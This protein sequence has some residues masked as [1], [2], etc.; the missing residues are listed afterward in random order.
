M[1]PPLDPEVIQEMR[2]EQRSIV[3][4]V[5][6]NCSGRSTIEIDTYRIKTLE[7]SFLQNVS[8]QVALIDA[9]RPIAF[10]LKDS[11]TNPEVFVPLSKRVVMLRLFDC[12]GPRVTGKLPSLNLPSLLLFIVHRCRQPINVLKAD[13]ETNCLLRGVEFTGTPLAFF[14]EGSFTNL[15]NLRYLALE[16]SGNRRGCHDT[17]MQ[18]LKTKLHCDCEYRWL[19]I[20]LAKNPTVIS[21]I[22]MTEIID[23]GQQY[24]TSDRIAIYTPIDCANVTYSNCREPSAQMEYS[25][26][27]PC[28]WK[29]STV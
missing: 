7:V 28:I 9:N 16:R 14:G 2:V 23:F 11:E 29:S 6:R 25:I 27:D 22:N 3:T 20:F 13:F 21:S 26:N 12:I 10:G 17:T 1:F 4:C 8:S 18:P 19:R 15:P 5:P 24:G